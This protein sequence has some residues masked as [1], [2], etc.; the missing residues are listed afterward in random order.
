MERPL[1]DLALS[2]HVQKV[3]LIPFRP[4]DLPNLFLIPK[5]ILVA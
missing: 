2:Q 5:T 3:T 4:N 1:E